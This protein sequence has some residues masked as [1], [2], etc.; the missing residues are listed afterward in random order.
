MVKNVVKSWKTSV[1]GLLIFVG[2]F[3]AVYIVG[4]MEFLYGGAASLGASILLLF[5]PDK[6]LRF[7]KRKSQNV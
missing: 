1:L 2:A 7:L 4:K 3:Y 5:A 6:I